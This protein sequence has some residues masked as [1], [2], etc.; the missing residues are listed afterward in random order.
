[1]TAST[2]LHPLAQSGGF[3][4][5]VDSAN[6]IACLRA[7]IT[8][9]ADHEVND[10]YDLLKLPPE[11]RIVDAVLIC[12]DLDTGTPAILLQVGVIDTVQDPSDTT[13]VDAIFAG[14][15]TAQAGG[16]ARA[17]LATCF[18]VAVRSYERI[19]RLQIATG[20]ATAVTGQV[21]LLLYVSPKQANGNDLAVV[22]P[23]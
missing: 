16:V 21:E 7:K 4:Y 12:S 22:M 15:T 13:D 2:Q 20:A 17:T 9:P 10:K 11:H 23:T 14:L 8:V 5:S 19:V 18:N 3:A 6:E 1:M